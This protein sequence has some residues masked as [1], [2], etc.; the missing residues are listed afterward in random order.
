MKSTIYLYSVLSSEPYLFTNLLRTLG[1]HVIQ[2]KGLICDSQHNSIECRRFY[3][4]AE[5]HG[6]HIKTVQGNT[7]G[8]SYTVQLTSCMTG[9]ESAI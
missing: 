3:Y 1:W 5:C 8:G 9:L 6:A 4:Y 7:K 2:H